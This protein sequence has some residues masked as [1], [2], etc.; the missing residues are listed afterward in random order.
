[1]ITAWKKSEM[2][3]DVWSAV[4]FPP[5]PSFEPYVWYHQSRDKTSGFYSIKPVL[6]QL[7]WEIM[8][9]RRNPPSVCWARK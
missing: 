3:H 6:S 1:M 9:H 5:P 4:V 2:S 7:C 8:L